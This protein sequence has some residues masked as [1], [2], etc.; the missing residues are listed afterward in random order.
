MAKNK[1]EEAIK[2]KWGAD[3]APPI[4]DKYLM[5]G[6]D[7]SK[8]YD[9]GTAQEIV[10]DYDFEDEIFEDFEEIGTPEEKNSK[11]LEMESKHSRFVAM[12]L[13][14]GSQMLSFVLDG[15]A[16]F[17]WLLHK[18][19]FTDLAE[20]KRLIGKE[21]FAVM[22]R[23]WYDYH[24]LY[25]LLVFHR[26]YDVLAYLINTKIID[27]RF[28]RDIRSRARNTIKH[29]TSIVNGFIELEKLLDEPLR[30][31]F[32]PL[33]DQT[34]DEMFGVGSTKALLRKESGR[35]SSEICKLK[36]KIVK[37]VESNQ[38]L[39][40]VLDGK[41]LEKGD[42]EVLK[43]VDRYLVYKYAN[44]GKT[45]E[46]RKIPFEEREIGGK[47]FKT[48]VAKGG[49][50][51]YGNGIIGVKPYKID[52][53]RLEREASGGAVDK[54]TKPSPFK[55]VKIVKAVAKKRKNGKSRPFRKPKKS[56]FKD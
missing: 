54:T 35:N 26:Q 32:S 37:L 42:Y 52:K 33:F 34:V 17:R 31:I 14:R 7:H 1:L 3:K 29:K 11:D 27:T 18:K 8:G 5:D 49:T 9:R 38:K 2:D 41:R 43:T 25:R 44:D 28:V 46:I 45:L 22:M 39:M 55:G 12:V 30:A 13:A 47:F 20:F 15:E 16:I 6:I 48:K 50:V 53:E 36:R 10:D 40:E 24:Y 19:R 4:V 56:I 51:D 21:N 23:K